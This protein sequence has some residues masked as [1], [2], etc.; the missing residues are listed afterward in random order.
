MTDLPAGPEWLT[1]RQYAA[2][3]DR[4]RATVSAWCRHGLIAAQRFGN[5]GNAQWMI[6]TGT[7]QPADKR[8][9]YDRS[10]IK[11]AALERARSL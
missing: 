3:V 10:A 8:G 7:V 2:Q 1:V 9:K 4:T 6:P 11:A 5:T